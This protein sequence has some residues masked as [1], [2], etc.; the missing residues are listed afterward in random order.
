MYS[1]P[2][3]AITLSGTYVG[4][5][6]EAMMEL[7]KIF[8]PISSTAISCSLSST[9]FNSAH[10]ADTPNGI[11]AYVSGTPGGTFVNSFAIGISTSTIEARDDVI[12]SGI[13]TQNSNIFLDLVIDS[14]GVAAAYNLTTF[15]MFDAIYVLNVYG[16][17]EV[18]Y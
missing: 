7:L 16:L 6:S 17:F 5:Y 15:A 18:R 14:A 4:G 10:T 2:Q 11:Q 9:T 13:S 12:M 1:Y 3:K 8:H